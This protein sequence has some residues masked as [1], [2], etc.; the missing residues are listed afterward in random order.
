MTQATTNR[1]HYALKKSPH[2]SHHR[3]LALLVNPGER[4]RV[5][6]VGAGTGELSL[7]LAERGYEVTAVERFPISENVAGRV[8]FYQADLDEALPPLKGAYDWILCADVLEHVRE[9]QILLQRLHALL[10]PGGVVLASLP[11]SGHWY[12][13]IHIFFGSFPRH[14]KGLFDRTHLHFFMWRNWLDLFQSAG[15]RVDAPVVTAPPADLKFPNAAGSLWLRC[16]D[17]VSRALAR[18]WKELFAYQFIVVVR[19]VRS[20][21][22]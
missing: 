17:A 18:F 12:F 1:A 9:P 10:T 5:L 21:R 3:I 14:D 20:G 4:R 7:I 6:D 22:Q 2:S 19:P 16:L 15:Y 8:E 13:R 11:N